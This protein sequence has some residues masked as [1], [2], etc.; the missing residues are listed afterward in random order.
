MKRGFAVS[1]FM[2]ST[3]IAVA[4]V[5][6]NNHVLVGQRSI[7]AKD[8]AGLQEFPG[9][10]IERDETPEE[11]AERECL[12]ETGIRISVLRVLDHVPSFS[13]QGDLDVFFFLATPQDLSQV[14]QAPFLYHAIE[15]INKEKF[16]FA[17]ARVIDWL[18][19][20][21]GGS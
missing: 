16:P 20:N 9:G 4:L 7:N 17:N 14:P 13:N 2:A 18:Q 21:Y 1:F 8:A 3:Q 11:A 5:I 19:N 6:R 10:K 15:S 12:E